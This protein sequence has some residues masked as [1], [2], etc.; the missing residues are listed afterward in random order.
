MR[1]LAIITFLTLDGVMQAPVQPEE[2]LSGGFTQG[3]WSADYFDGVM[4]QVNEEAMAAPVDLLFG[5]KT[6]E[7]FAAHW[8]H[9]GDDNLHARIL[10]NANKFVATSTLS[11]LEWSNSKPITGDIVEEVSRLKKQDGPLLQVHGSWQLAQTLL[12]HELID[13]FRLW[14]FPV[15]VGSGKRLFNQDVV[16]TNLT[17]VKTKANSNG[18]VMSIY[19]R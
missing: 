3:G 2:D 19:R 18:V 14:V 1:D 15:V 7:L 6:Y 17:L 13:E 4:E 8:P 11:R 10:N 16:P 12:A 5:R 9:V